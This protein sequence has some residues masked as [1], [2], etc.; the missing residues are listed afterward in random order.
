MDK[1]DGINIFLSEGAGLDAILKEMKLSKVVNN[2]S[3]SCLL[4]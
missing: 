3:K 2:V 4:S 1:K